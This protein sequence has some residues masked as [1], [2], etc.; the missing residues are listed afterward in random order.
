MI[1]WQRLGS[2]RVSQAEH[3]LMK[4][5][6]EALSFQITNI[7]QIS[8]KKYILG[9]NKH[10]LDKDKKYNKKMRDPHHK[11]LTNH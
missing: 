6:E 8:D 3:M 7:Y 1:G 5:P 2:I 10:I 4:M 9:Y 11:I